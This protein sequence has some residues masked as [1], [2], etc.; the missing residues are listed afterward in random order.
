MEIGVDIVYIPRLKLLNKNSLKKIF[1]ENE[2][3]N[4][5]ESLAGILAAK[6]ALIKAYD[7]KINFLDINILKLKSGKPKVLILNNNDEIK[8]SISHDKDY[9]I[10]Q[11]LVIK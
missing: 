6:E 2:L 1:H 4:T 9:A 7:K 10:A 5:L 3:N 8:M 11:V